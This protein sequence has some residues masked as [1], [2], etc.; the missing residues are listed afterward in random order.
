MGR[1]VHDGGFRRR[2]L[3]VIEEGGGDPFV[4]Q[5]PPVLR[6]IEELDDVEVAI[7]AFEQV[8][9]RATAHFPD[10]A[11]GVDGHGWEMNVSF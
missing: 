11:G 9:L 10:E 2:D 4:D 8:G 3:Q 6:I 5:Y 1:Q 7:V